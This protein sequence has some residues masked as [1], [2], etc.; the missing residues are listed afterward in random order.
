MMMVA[1]PVERSPDSDSG[2]IDSS[3]YGNDGNPGVRH[4]HSGS[5]DS[6]SLGPD[7]NIGFRH[8]D[9]SSDDSGS[10]ADEREMEEVLIDNFQLLFG[11]STTRNTGVPVRDDRLHVVNVRPAQMAVPVNFNGAHV[12]LAGM[13]FLGNR[14]ISKT[15]KAAYGHHQDQSYILSILSRKIDTYRC[16]IDGG[17]QD[18]GVVLIENPPP[19]PQEIYHDNDDDLADLPDLEN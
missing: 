5:D 15:S 17:H 19:H 13:P 7:G 16:I 9:S 3:D 12:Q 11:V 1:P 4:I 8:V 6:S 10:L 2:S 18:G 14:V